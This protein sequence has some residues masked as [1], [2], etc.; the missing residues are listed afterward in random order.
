MPSV[1]WKAQ[2]MWGTVYSISILCINDTVLG[3]L[4]ESICSG[5]DEILVCSVDVQVPNTGS[6]KSSPFPATF[7][8]ICDLLL[9]PEQPHALWLTLHQNAFIIN[10][11]YLD[12]R[13]C[14]RTNVSGRNHFVCLA[15]YL[16]VYCDATPKPP[17][18][19]AHVYTLLLLSPWIFSPIT[20]S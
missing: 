12:H 20:H 17:I 18:T 7:R 8:N 16:Y 11:C 6:H 19:N 14:K 10:T 4:N 3:T 13:Y 1:A 5:R 2:L 9:D 15:C